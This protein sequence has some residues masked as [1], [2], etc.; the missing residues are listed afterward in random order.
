MNLFFSYFCLLSTQPSTKA[1]KLLSEYYH[2]KPRRR[3][4]TFFAFRNNASYFF[5]SP[6]MLLL[7]EN[8]FFRNGTGMIQLRFIYTLV[9]F[10]VSRCTPPPSL[11]CDC[12][13][14]FTELRFERLALTRRLPDTN[15]KPLPLSGFS[16]HTD[17]TL[18]LH[19]STC[20]MWLKYFGNILL[21]S[22]TH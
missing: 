5:S 18:S 14:R 16:S 3:E 17:R 4:H 13:S 7:S 19:Y 2:P 6:A 12:S 9:F 20:I 15:A 21:C 22:V 8:L 10:P 11:V 1:R